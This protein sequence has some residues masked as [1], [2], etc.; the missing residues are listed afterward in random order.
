M[1]ISHLFAALLLVC[2]CGASEA[3]PRSPA[4]EAPPPRFLDPGLQRAAEAAAPASIRFVTSDDFP[5]FN[6]V[7][8]GGHLIGY[9]VEL[10]RA[11]CARA[12]IPCTI[13]VRP[14][15]DL[16]AAIA[17]N[18]A[19]A[20]VAGLDPAAAGAEGLLFTRPFFRLP[21]RFVTRTSFTGD[22]L[23][24]TLAGFAV[25]VVTGSAEEPYLARHF[26]QS[27]VQPFA[28][29]AGALAALEA[30]TVEAVFAGSLPLAF[31][32]A[33]PGAA[34]C[35]RFAGPAYAE[36]RA[37]RGALRIAVGGDEPA[38]RD[39]LDAGL[40][41]LEADGTLDALYRRFFPIGLY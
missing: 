17:G 40:A 19:D 16:A 10:A 20:V 41:R 13:Q 25:G 33:G 2:V 7:D 39:F 12:D 6:F 5:P 24:E 37:F 21:A 8:G 34:G 36:P 4:G 11:L 3:A 27:R 23:P 18:E 9:H 22:A 31:W 1:R 15:E 38:L 14:F 26:P 29:L 32:L 35:C 30:G 28:D